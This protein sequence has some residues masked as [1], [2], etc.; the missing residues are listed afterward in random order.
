[1]ND[2]AAQ[3]LFLVLDRAFWLIWLGFPMLIWLL[4][5][6]IL[7]APAQLAVLA[8]DQAACLEGLPMV[9]NFSAVSQTAFW[10]QFA[11]EMTVYAVLL[12]LAHRVIHRCA[13]GQVFVAA[14]IATLRRIGLV[15]AIYPL[16]ELV[17]SNLT[18]ITYTL[19]GDLAIYLP[20]YALNL[21]VIAVGLLL[22]TMAS[23]MRMAVHLHREAELTI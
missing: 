18:L 12:W 9:S 6:Q 2:L 1:M 23:A 22:I 5:H 19:A 20:D 14:M 17:L 3:R 15:I 8:P 7:D 21:P 10:G 13:T 4:V 16:V 11:V